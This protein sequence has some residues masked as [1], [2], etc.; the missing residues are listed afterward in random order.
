MPPYPIANV[1]ATALQP[2]IDLVGFGNLKDSFPPGSQF[3]IA[4]STWNDGTYQVVGAGVVTANGATSVFRITV[5]GLPAGVADGAVVPAG[6]VLPRRTLCHGSV[7]QVPAELPLPPASPPACWTWRSATLRSRRW[8]RCWGRTWRC[9]GSPPRTSPGCWRRSSTS[10]R[11]HHAARRHLLHRPPRPVHCPPPGH[12]PELRGP[13]RLPAGDAEPERAVPVPQRAR[14]PAH[15]A[16]ADLAAPVFVTLV[17]D[18]RAEVHATS[19]ILPVQSVAVESDQ[20]A[21]ALAALDVT[22]LSGPV[23]GGID[24]VRVPLPAFQAGVWSWVDRPG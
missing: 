7:Y 24:Q 5:A 22:F 10:W 6:T 11:G 17:V 23:P 16:P 14:L 8:R 12:R 3:Q 13:F 18:P 1:D 9:P 15:D 21:D 2:T 4:G 20:V 19:G